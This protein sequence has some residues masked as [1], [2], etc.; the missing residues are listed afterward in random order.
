MT[1]AFAVLYLFGA[2]LWTVL[3]GLAWSENRELGD[4]RRTRVAARWLLLAPVW[5]VAGAWLL[6]TWLAIV[7]EDAR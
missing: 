5:P 4:D 7:R 3:F 6:M 1:V 2:A